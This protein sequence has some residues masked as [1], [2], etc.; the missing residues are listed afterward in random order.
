[1]RLGGFPC[2]L[3]NGSL[4]M[5]VYGSSRITERHRHRYEFNN[6]YREIMEAKG[7]LLSGL[8]P[9][10]GLV[11]MVEITD[12]PWFL[13]CQFHPE[14]QSTPMKAHPLFREFVGASLRRRDEIAGGAGTEGF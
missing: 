1:M 7:M 4:A 14:F 8:S 9:D 11:E 6:A 10:G 12:H 2:N 3:V 5:S 13:A